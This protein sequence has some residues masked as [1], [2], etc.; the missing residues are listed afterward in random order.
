MRRVAEWEF[1]NDRAA[2]EA[3]YSAAPT[4]GT[5]ECGCETCRNYALVRERVLPQEFVSFLR[6]VGIDPCKEAEAYHNAR[7]SRGVHHYGGWYHFVGELQ[8][9][10]DFPM[11]EAAPGFRYFL[12]RAHASHLRQLDGLP[13]V[14]VGFDA[15]AVPWELNEAEP[16]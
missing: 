1:S 10:G 3:A 12:C 15:T 7:M 6:S 8:K 2:T 13:L 14:E 5:E 9:T 4:G 16:E 11:I